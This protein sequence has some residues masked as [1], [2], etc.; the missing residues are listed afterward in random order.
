MSEWSKEHALSKGLLRRK[1]VYVKSV[2]RARI[3]IVMYYSYIL[4][5]LKDQKFYYGST[6]DLD[7]RLIKHNKG[8]VKATKFRRPLVLHFY[9]EHESRS[10]AYQRE[11]FYKS[12]EGYKY[13]KKK[14]II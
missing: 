7:K 5:S 2:S 6:Q 14:N 3:R 10:L 4:K 12:I 9:E 13:L 11:L 8:D 1:C